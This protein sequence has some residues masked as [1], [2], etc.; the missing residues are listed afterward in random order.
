MLLASGEVDIQPITNHIIKIIAQNK[1][2]ENWDTSVIVHY[3]KNKGGWSY[4][5]TQ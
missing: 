3:F 5:N 2:S 1:V 4:Y